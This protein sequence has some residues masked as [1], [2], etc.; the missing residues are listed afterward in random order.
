MQRIVQRRRRRR[1]A[2]M[3]E[4][5]FVFPFSMVLVMFAV[6]I[7]RVYMTL[8]AV[9]YAA[10]RAARAGALYGAGGFDAPLRS[11]MCADAVAQSGVRPEFISLDTFCQ[12]LNSIPGGPTM[13]E[14]LT[15]VSI[16]GGDGDANNVCTATSQYVTVDVKMSIPSFT[17]GI[18]ALLALAG[19][20]G[21]WEVQASQT[22][23][24][25]RRPVTP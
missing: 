19:S 24:C 2:A 11:D 7:G 1:G 5:M 17:P 10:S 18:S 21:G 23:V 12:K 22:A 14:R 25:P 15:S 9:E 8:N 4:F 13:V 6:D 20:D 16:V 3:L